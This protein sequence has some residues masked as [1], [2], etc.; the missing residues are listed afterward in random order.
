M[1]GSSGGDER[2]SRIYGVIRGPHEFCWTGNLKNWN[3]LDDLRRIS[4]PTLIFVGAHDHTTPRARNESPRPFPA[5]SC[6][7]PRTTVAASCAKHRSSIAPPCSTSGIVPRESRKSLRFAPAWATHELSPTGRADVR[8]DA[9]AGCSV[10]CRGTQS[11][12]ARLSSSSRFIALTKIVW[13]SVRVAR[14][15]CSTRLV[16]SSARRRSVSD[17]SAIWAPRCAAF[18]T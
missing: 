13:N 14:A 2:N 7:S 16:I 17:R 18:P 15:T 11:E 1:G 3:R 10:P 12:T 9:R 6:A 4:C 8:R 5:P